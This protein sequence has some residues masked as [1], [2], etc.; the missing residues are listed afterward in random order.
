MKNK[1]TLSLFWIGIHILLGLLAAYSPLIAKAWGISVIVIGFL[2]I[3]KNKNQNNE[4]ALWVAYY[5]GL[6]ILLRMTGGEF[7][8][9]FG[10][11]TIIL[12]LGY[13]FFIE[14]REYTWDA[15]WIIFV[16]FLLFPAVLQTFAWSERIREDILF[17]ISGMMALCMSVIYFYKR[18]VSFDKLLQVL[19]YFILPVIALCADLFI[20]TPDLSKIKF[21][22]GAN[23][24]TSGGFGP[25]QVATIL[26]AGWM[27]VIIFFLY[28]KK[29]TVYLWID[30]LLFVYILYRALFT[31]SRGGNFGAILALICFVG[32]HLA[33][34]NHKVISVRTTFSILLLAVISWFAVNY[35][36]NITQGV[37]S[38][39][40]TGKTAT[41]ELKADMTSGRVSILE[42]EIDIFQEHILGVGAGGSAHFRKIEF[43]EEY[44]THNEFGRLVSEHGI[45]GILTILLLIYQPLALFFKMSFIDN[46]AFLVLFLVISFSTMMH[47]A[48]RVALPAFFYGM[49]MIYFIP[50]RNN[51]D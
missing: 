4:A 3:H 18:P 33:Y 6:E 51:T 28:R 19:S 11:Y 5:V 9:E 40:F 44:A 39:R 30:I 37:F 15:R 10:K 42:K 34:K 26:G 47:S 2:S 36:D 23:F 32:V 41:G 17:N 50:E 25:N 20:K 27:I 12:L 7:T 43:N 8:W 29:L 46:R 14:Q 13:G 21:T 1:S 24:A 49:S 38:N 22:T 35:I 45:F 16:L 31:F 48:M